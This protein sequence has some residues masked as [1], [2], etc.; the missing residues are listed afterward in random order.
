MDGYALLRILPTLARMTRFAI[1]SLVGALG[2]TLLVL[3][4][5][6]T[7]AA[8]HHGYDMDCSSF[9]SQAS[10]QS[11][12]NAHPG[13]PDGLDGSDDDGLACESNSC[14]CYYGG[15]TQP[16]PAPPSPPPAPAPAPAPSPIA[17]PQAQAKRYSARIVG[18]TDGDTIKVRLRSG[19]L[20]I[21]RLIGIDTPESR[22]PGVPVEC[23]ARSATNYMTKLA[24]RRRGGRT[25]GHS[26]RLTTDPTQDPV[27]RYGR[28]LAYV[29]RLSDGSDLGRSMIRAGW[30]MAYVYDSKPFQRLGSYSATQRLAEITNRGV[31][32]SC[33]G[34]FHSKQ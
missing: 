19:P 23:G 11:H 34:D 25:L 28:L 30:A 15:A 20:R 16:E 29:N 13:D 24:F 12:M 18:V 31:W 26:V 33:E 5:L 22:K 4:L 17:Q 32:A 2:A 1:A 21:V 6:A 14:P 10:A 3:V 8:A 27:D 7:P 9:S